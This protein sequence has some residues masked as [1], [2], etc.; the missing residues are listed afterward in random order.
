MFAAA[1]LFKLGRWPAL[2]AAGLTTWA[3][4]F[5]SFTHWCWFI[6]MIEY[7]FACYLC[8]I[9]LGLFYRFVSE[10][11]LW[12]A[13]ASA[14][15]LGAALIVHP[16]VFVILVAPMLW[17]WLANFRALDRRGHA[18]VVG[19]AVVAI[20]M[21]LWWLLVAFR[22]WH[23]IMDSAYFGQTD[24]RFVIADLTSTLLDTET[25]GVIGTRTG[26]RFLFLIAGAVQ[27]RRWF[28]RGDARAPLFTVALVSLLLLTYVGGYTQVIAQIQPYRFVIP[29]AFIAL[30]PASLCLHELVGELR[31]GEIDRKGKVLALVLALPAFQHLVDDVLYFTPELQPKT[32]RLFNGEP[33]MFAGSGYFPHMTMRHGIHP[34]DRA[35]VE[36]IRKREDG[37]GRWL[38]EWP[39]L[40]DE[41]SW[42]TDAQV[43]G[44]LPFLNLEHS[45]ANLYRRHPNGIVADDELRE[46]IETYAVSWVVVSF[47]TARFN[48]TP[49]P[50][51]D[52]VASVGGHQ[53]YR[54][55][56]AVNLVAEGGG[57]VRA[58]T[59]RIRV[60]G[61]DPEV[62]S[63]IRYHWMETLVCRPDCTIERAEIDGVD[64]VG[65][66]RVPAPHP[67]D[68]E[69]V[70]AY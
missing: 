2:V 15:S 16:Y 9:P 66:I 1:R 3:W 57:K 64:P 4:F 18:L 14:L 43:L 17:L 5:D 59:N 10:Q 26:F 47:P 56:V 61:S 62:D 24:L 46:Y 33:S 19:V 12:Q 58:E 32:G 49:N 25:S 63:V 30:I 50:W 6:G 13:I 37:R 52:R 48:T 21:N 41:I 68:Y 8:L 54:T 65:F 28:K 51:M 36:W 7:A 55:K 31:R 44:G 53:I 67:A 40:A 69:I 27:I 35:L 22:F 70:N 23:Y 20:V 34:G 60:S 11:R 42:Q 29:T 39:P 38:V 45:Y